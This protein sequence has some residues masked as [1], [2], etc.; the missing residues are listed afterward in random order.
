M[1][2]EYISKN[3][4]IYVLLDGKIGLNCD[5]FASQNK[6]FIHIHHINDNEYNDTL[7]S[8]FHHDVVLLNL[9]N[10]TSFRVDTQNFT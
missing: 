10:K 5:I 9:F 3:I 4:I 2:E 6:Y 7:L 8:L 1:L